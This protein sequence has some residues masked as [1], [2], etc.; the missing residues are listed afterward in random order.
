VT[1]FDVYKLIRKIRSIFYILAIYL[2]TNAVIFA[3]NIHRNMNETFYNVLHI[4][5][6]VRTREH[7]YN[8]TT[9]HIYKRSPRDHSHGETRAVRQRREPLRVS[10]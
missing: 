7:N 10:R 8:G 2:P 5:W 1:K 9:R 6:R 3:S 4:F